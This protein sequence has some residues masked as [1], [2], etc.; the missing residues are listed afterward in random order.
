MEALANS[1]CYGGLDL[2]QNRDLTAFALAFKNPD[3]GNDVLCWHWLPREV[4][5][6]KEKEMGLPYTEWAKAGWIELTEGD[7]IDFNFIS[8]R[9]IEICKQYNVNFVN[10]DPHNAASIKNDMEAAGI[11]V[12]RFSQG[13]TTMNWPT[14]K[15][16]NLIL[17]GDFRHGDNPLLRWEF[18]NLKIARNDYGS[19]RPTK[20][21]MNNKIDGVVASIMALAPWHPFE[22]VDAQP[23]KKRGVRFV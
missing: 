7:Y 5:M 14:K 11:E 8:K 12:Q 1:E 17:A 3:G 23:Y 21:N 9:L 22:P 4:A 10:F 6:V 15:L 18:S 19:I 2:S 20:S 13:F 16:E